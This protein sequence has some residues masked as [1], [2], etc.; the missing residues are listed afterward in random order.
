MWIH[1]L[2]SR[3]HAILGNSHF[4]LYH[5]A[6]MYQAINDSTAGA[7][8]TA[9][10][11]GPGSAFT[12]R[13]GPE[14]GTSAT[15]YSSTLRGTVNST[16]NGTLVECFGPNLV[17]EP[18]NRVGESALQ[19]LGNSVKLFV[20]IGYIPHCGNYMIGATGKAG[21]RKSGTGIEMVNKNTKWEWKLYKEAP[22]AR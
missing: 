9:A 1:S 15:S 5:M 10:T 11:C 20:H 16:L 22:K 6:I 18:R 12:V 2:S 19:I 4:S 8:A 3:P 7:R 21:K 13:P 14:F 17:R